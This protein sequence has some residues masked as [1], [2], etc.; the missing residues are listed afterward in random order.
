MY[1][2][3]A[4]FTVFSVYFWKYADEEMQRLLWMKILWYRVASLVQGFLARIFLEEFLLFGESPHFPLPRS[5]CNPLHP[6]DL[7]PNVILPYLT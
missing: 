4:Y 1:R 7:Y 5:L 6:L 3:I 2:R